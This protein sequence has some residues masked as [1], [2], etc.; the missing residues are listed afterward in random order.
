[1]DGYDALQRALFPA[2]SH[3]R[4]KREKAAH[5][6]DKKHAGRLIFHDPDS[7]HDKRVTPDPAED[8]VLRSRRR[9]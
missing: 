9:S 3:L 2:G 6:D 1:M 7:E 5:H 8:L 4:N